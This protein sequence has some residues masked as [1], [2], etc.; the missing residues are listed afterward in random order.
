MLRA[1]DQYPP[2]ITRH[3]NNGVLS[4]GRSETGGLDF[5]VN[6]KKNVRVMLTSNI[7]IADRL[8]NDQMGTVIKIHVDKV[9]Q[10]PAVVYIKF[11]DNKAGSTLIQSSR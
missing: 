4:R 2:N 10:R 5:E 6:I 8:I 3:Y 9:T 11:D 7:N 1:T